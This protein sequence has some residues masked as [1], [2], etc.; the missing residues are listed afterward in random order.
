MDIL[1]LLYLKAKSYLKTT[2]DNR[3]QDLVVLGANV[4]FDKRQDRYQVYGMTVSDFALQS[5]PYK[6]YVAILTQTGTAAPTVA[7]VLDN[8]LGGTIVWTRTAAGNYTGT[9]TGAFTA[10]KTIGVASPIAFSATAMSVASG[11]IRQN[12]ANTV[13]LLTYGGDG[14]GGFIYGDFSGGGAFTGTIIVDIKV[15]L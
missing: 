8:T 3:N 9:L 1:N 4:G 5:R 14:S 2:V 11:A 12:N 7:T 10:S 6:S 13:N 15:Y